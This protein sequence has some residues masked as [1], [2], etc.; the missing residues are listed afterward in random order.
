LAWSECA[1]FKPQPG[2]APQYIA[3]VAVSVWET[4]P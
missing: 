4:L 2:A 3:R 1:I